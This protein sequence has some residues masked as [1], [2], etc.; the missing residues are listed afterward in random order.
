MTETVFI[1][2]I[3]AEGDNIWSRPP[4]ITTENARFL[5]R[6]QT[7]CERYGFKPTYL[8]N[9]EMVLDIGFQEFGRGVLRRSAGEIGLHIHPWFSPPMDGA[10]DPR[11]PHLYLY[12]LP[13]GL[14]AAKVAALT[15][16]LAQ[17]FEV[18]PISH[19][20]GKWGFDE[21]VARALVDQKFEVD[22]S[23]TPG[24]SWRRYLGSH[25]G[26]GGPDYTEFPME[27]YFLN[28]NDIRRPGA[29]P[30]LEVPMTV[31]PNYRSSFARRQRRLHNGVLGKVMQKILGAPYSWLRP[32]GRNLNALLSL[33]D[34]GASCHFP[35]LEFMLHSSELM[36]GGSPTFRTPDEIEVLY[37]HLARL[38]DHVAS[39]GIR[40]VTLAEF[41]RCWDVTNVSMDEI[42]A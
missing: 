42:Y 23:V 26:H 15:D 13:D 6:F 17:T 21:R 7:L 31:R 16:L 33:V 18:Q 2:T 29:S 10:Y 30:L 38:F 12:D 22:C 37:T 24:L 34:W 39:L 27:P 32:N 41:R 28:L 1:I 25:N 40:G 36:P 8:V 14:L 19:R 20:A 9:Y 4:R 35:V 5:P 3:D 11:T